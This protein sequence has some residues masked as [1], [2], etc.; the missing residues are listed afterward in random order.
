MFCLRVL[1][2]VYEALYKVKNVAAEW[3]AIFKKRH[4][5]RDTSL[6]KSQIQGFQDFWSGVG[7]P[8]I[9][10][11]W[12]R[13]YQSINGKFDARYIPD[14]LFSI[15]MERVMNPRALSGALSDKALAQHVYGQVAGVRFPRMILCVANGVSVDAAGSSLTRLEAIGLMAAHDQMVA[16]PLTDG[17]S[18]KGVK[19]YA[20][21]DGQ[22]SWATVFDGLCRDFPKGFLIQ[23][24]VTSHPFLTT[25]SPS[26]LSTIRVITFTFEGRIHHALSALRMGLG[27]S[28]IDNIHAGGLVVSVDE[29]GRLGRYAYQLGYC[30]S[31]V[32]F[33]THPE[34]DVRFSDLVLPGMNDVICAAK[35]MHGRTPGLGMISW[36]M[37]LSDAN[38]VVC[39]EA[40]LQ[41]Q[42]VWF[43]QICHGEPLFGDLTPQIL[44]SI[45]LPKGG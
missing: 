27:Q 21:K 26:A 22:E 7:L 40:N 10:S 13:L 9:S 43:P 4:L 12:H 14:H 18:G 38:E 37:T 1:D 8:R 24:R 32:R 45:F 17:N 20:C 28:F 3:C 15:R 5:Y 29:D 39:I 16:K 33:D 25:L 36:D 35:R 42:S 34:C 44:K 19:L 11:K 41:G 30:D 2:W 6:S 23:E 31:N